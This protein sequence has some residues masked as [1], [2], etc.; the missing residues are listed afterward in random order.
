MLPRV[1]VR[2]RGGKIRAEA[3][4]AYSVTAPMIYLLIQSAYEKRLNVLRYHAY[5]R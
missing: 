2:V 3:A 1:R 5:D 4:R